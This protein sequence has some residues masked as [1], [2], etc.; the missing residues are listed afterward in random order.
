[1]EA[2]NE[3]LKEFYDQIA[4][5]FESKLVMHLGYR[6]PWVLYDMVSAVL[7]KEYSSQIAGFY[8]LS[9]PGQLRILDLGCG[10]GLCGRVFGH[11]SSGPA[12][13]SILGSPGVTIDETLR[14]L[15]AV[16]DNESDIFHITKNIYNSMELFAASIPPRGA[17]F[18]GID[19]SANMVKI[20]SNPI[21]K[22][23]HLVCG[24]LVDGL[25]S[26]SSRMES[27]DLVV[28][29]DTFIYVGALGKVFELLSTVLKRRGIV[30][31]STELLEENQ[32]TCEKKE[33]NIHKELIDGELIYNI[34]DD[35]K[36]RLGFKLMESARFGHQVQY[37]EDLCSLFKFDLVS[38]EKRIL[39]TESSLP[40]SGMFYVLQRKED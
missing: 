6:G 37:I 31:F 29:A 1:M 36:P 40:V 15:D 30:A 3:Y 5:S 32:A 22:Y 35:G 12:D 4:V 28:A 7:E 39:R 34:G 21:N 24:H 10:S 8:P 26:F 19:I 11:L 25:H 13:V 18:A 16:S 27:L 2:D 23:S 20:S 17:F 38:M 33:E 9:A 14:T